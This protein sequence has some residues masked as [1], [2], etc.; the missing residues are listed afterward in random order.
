[1]GKVREINLRD[2]LIENF[3]V[4]IPNKRGISKPY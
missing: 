4:N 2:T 1:M 3:K